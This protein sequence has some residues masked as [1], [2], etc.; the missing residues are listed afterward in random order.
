MPR[1]DRANTPSAQASRQSPANLLVVV[2]GSGY[3]GP[4]RF[5]RTA[6]QVEYA[7]EIARI[8]YVHRIG[9]R[10]DRRPGLVISRLQIVIENIVPVI[11]RNEPLHWQSHPFGEQSRRQIAE[12]AARHADD[13]R[14][15]QAGLAQPGIGVEIVERLRQK[16]RDVD[17]IAEVSE[18]RSPS[19]RSINAALTS[20]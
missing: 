18:R 12:I 17:R 10:S 2:A 16:A 14:S 3:V 13:D 6:V 7:G 19:S 5:E 4:D 15:R 1:A 8:A 9:D 11:G 20:R